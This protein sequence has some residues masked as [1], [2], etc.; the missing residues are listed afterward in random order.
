V[1]LTLGAFG[2]EEDCAMIGGL[3]ST[4]DIGAGRLSPT[5][6]PHDPSK[7]YK[8]RDTVSWQD[9]EIEHLVD[10]LCKDFPKKS[11]ATIERVI[12]ACKESVQPSAGRERLID[13]ARRSLS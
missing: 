5:A 3:S 6:M 1:S 11:R 4:L 8:D 13:C 9:W 2:I 7:R 12:N 10:K